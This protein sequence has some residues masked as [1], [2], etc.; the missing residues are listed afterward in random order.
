MTIKTFIMRIILLFLILI[1]TSVNAQKSRVCGVYD[2]QDFYRYIILELKDNNEF[3]LHI[4]TWFDHVKANGRF[5]LNN[6]TIVFEQLAGDSIKYFNKIS[7]V[8]K[9]EIKLG[10]STLS[11]NKKYRKIDKIPFEKSNL[12]SFVE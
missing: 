7:L 10:I 1:T 8:R 4:M 3:N 6:D 9:N 12:R 5:V 11:K 2:S